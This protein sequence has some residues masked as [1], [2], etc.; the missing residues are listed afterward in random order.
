MK[1]SVLIS[2]YYK[3]NSLFLEKAL[4]SI[5]NQTLFPNEIVLVKD[6]SLTKELNEVI[7]NFLNEYP[8]LMKVISLD[9]NK[10]LGKALSIGIKKCTYNL[11]A[12]MDAD[13][14]AKSNRFEKQIKVFRNN[15]ELVIVGSWVNEFEND[16]SSV[17]STRKVPQY[18]KEI[19]EFAKSRNP[20]NHPSVMIKKDFV[21]KA[22]NYLEFYLNEDYYLWLR[23]L[24]MGFK[25]YNIQESLLFFRISKDTF[26]RRGG[27]KYA[28][29]DIKLQN[30]LLKMEF[31]NKYEYIK[32]ILTRPI[33]RLLPNFMREQIYKNLLR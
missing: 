7:N 23:M 9:K 16:V 6:G 21:L 17:I 31:I 11:V 24:N 30:E 15:P 25:A 19:K 5:I 10:G 33:I 29:Q 32:N 14:I 2:V 13:D 3:E 22:G 4:K 28:V 8:N 18:N 12:R 26:K 27:L 1:F 20:F